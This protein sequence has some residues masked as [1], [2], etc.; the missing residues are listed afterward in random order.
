[1]AVGQFDVFK[2]VARMRING[3]D[4]A[5]NVWHAQIINVGAPTDEE[6]VEDLA[7]KL[8]TLYALVDHL[9]A[10]N[11]TFEDIT[12]FS[13]TEDRPI[14]VTT[15]PTLT[16]GL[17]TSDMLPAGIAALVT[18]PTGVTRSFGKKFLP[19]FTEGG[20]TE[21]GWVTATLTALAAFGVEALTTG[22]GPNFNQFSFGAFNKALADYRPF[23][24]ALVRGIEAY[25]RR[26]KPGVGS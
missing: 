26:R 11:L 17:T 15:W 21:D 1:M 10:N 3:T 7:D 16:V 23:I 13:V 20:R 2:V 9:M 4:E 6:V 25:Q 18:F 8:D 5:I 22:L 14:G 24:E 12:V 19:A